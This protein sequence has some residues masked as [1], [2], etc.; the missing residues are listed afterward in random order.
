MKCRGESRPTPQPHPLAGPEFWGPHAA[1][2]LK[3]QQLLFKE[4][5]WGDSRFV[6]ARSH[7][8][9][10]KLQKTQEKSSILHLTFL[11]YNTYD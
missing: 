3:H 4:Q 5:I 8:P 9:K 1:P 10:P 11:M 2:P 6:P 7:Q